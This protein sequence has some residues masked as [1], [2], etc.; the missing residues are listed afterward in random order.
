[1]R[2]GPIQTEKTKASIGWISAYTVLL[3]AFVYLRSSYPL[4]AI[5]SA[6]HDDALFLRLGIDI[7]QG[8]W[9]GAFDHKTLAKGPGLSLLLA[10]ADAIGV[11]F[12]IVEAVLYAGVVVSVAW[13]LGQLGLAWW[14]VVAVVFLLLANPYIWS[15]SGARLLREE[16]YISAFLM[17]LVLTLSLILT[18]QALWSQLVKGFLAGAFLG[19][20][21]LVREEDIWLTGILAVALTLVILRALIRGLISIQLKTAIQCCAIP[22]IFYLGFAAV[23]APVKLLNLQ[24]YGWGIVSEFRAEEFKSAVGALM[25]VGERH[26]SR[27]VYVT[28]EAMETAFAVSDAASTLEP[29]WDKIHTRWSRTGEYLNDKGDS[30]LYG[31]WYVWALRDAV[32]AAGHYKTGHRALSFYVELSRDINQACDAGR[33]A[34]RAR[35]DTI[36]PALMLRDIPRL[37]SSTAAGLWYTVR[38]KGSPDLFQSEDSIA[39]ERW[40]SLIGPVSS[41]NMRE[42]SPWFTLEGWVAHAGSKPNVSASHN[43]DM[44]GFQI[45]TSDAPG[46]DKYFARNGQPTIKSTK[47][48]ITDYCPQELCRLTVSNSEGDQIAVNIQNPTKRKL[49]LE[50]PFT[51]YLINVTP[52]Y[53]H[54]EYFVEKFQKTHLIIIKAAVNTVQFIIPLLTITATVGLIGYVFCLRRRPD[55]DKI[56]IVTIVAASAVISRCLII[57]YIDITSWRAVSAGYLG[58]AY[59]FMILYGTAGSILLTKLISR[60]PA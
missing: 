3:L 17:S 4:Y 46:V 51:G 49:S 59:P 29:V 16:L 54:K 57:G 33:I 60:R 6:G 24:Y 12:Q 43:Q 36:R 41:A 44:S 42:G 19:F 52:L 30:E 13:V 7:G 38:V 21:Y 56:A 28:N 45:E 5:T 48:K 27:Y 2:E 20:A 1:M 55:T 58:P 37:I 31:A 39:L 15:A 34:C 18:T 32:K 47:F 25:R 22:L 40:E 35:Q 50:S 26:P 9:L 14:T 10:V 11:W 23:V 8:S 53:S